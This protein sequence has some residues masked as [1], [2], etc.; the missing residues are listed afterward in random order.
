MCYDD[1][2]LK[3]MA[4][5]K[6]KKLLTKAQLKELEG[7][8]KFI[9]PNDLV[10]PFLLNKTN[11]WQ[12]WSAYKNE[13]F[14]SIPDYLDKSGFGDPKKINVDFSDVRSVDSVDSVD[15]VKRVRGEGKKPKKSTIMVR[16]EP[17]QLERL[18]QLGGNVSNHIRAAVDSYLDAK[19]IGEKP[20]AVDDG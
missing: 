16:F 3:I 8:L 7:V 17:I 10:I 4:N 12:V 19:R 2:G 9:I 13:T 5:M 6:V 11:Q 18:K 15:T 1:P 20:E 14:L